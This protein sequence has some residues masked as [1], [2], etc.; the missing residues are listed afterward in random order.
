MSCSNYLSTV[1]SLH[2]NVM[3]PTN[4]LILK[5]KGGRKHHTPASWVVLLRTNNN[6]F[7]FDSTLP[8]CC[9]FLQQPHSFVRPLQTELIELLQV[10]CVATQLNAFI[11]L[12]LSISW[13]AKSC[14]STTFRDGTR[15][16]SVG[17]ATGYWLNNRGVVLRIPVR[18]RIFTSPYRQDMLFYPMGTAGSFS[19]VKAAGS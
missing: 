3:P 15:G 16:G 13:L 5:E 6:Y 11:G 9:R 12:Q 10:S 14:N 17:I 4:I 8:N 2:K 19:A 1:W 18:S 7:T